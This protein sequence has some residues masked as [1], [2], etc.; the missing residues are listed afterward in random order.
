MA[1]GDEDEEEDGYEDEDDLIE[2]SPAVDDWE[3]GQGS[4]CIPITVSKRG[5]S[6]DDGLGASFGGM[7]ISP[8]QSRAAAMAISAS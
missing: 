2:E 8:A 4:S 7:S 1:I 5:E 6:D 3:Y